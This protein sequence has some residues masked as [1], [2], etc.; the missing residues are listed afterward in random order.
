MRPLLTLS[1]AITLGCNGLAGL[2]GLTFDD[3]GGAAGAAGAGGEGGTATGMGGTSS[4]MAGMGGSG[5]SGDGGM[6]GLSDLDL[7]VRY[8][9]DEQPSGTDPTLLEDSGFEK[10]SHRWV[11]AWEM[12][13]GRKSAKVRRKAGPAPAD[14]PAETRTA[15]PAQLP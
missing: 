14:R 12:E 10:T 1:I 6:G 15:E 3:V 4:G 8:R 7:V 9:M 2:D 5:A 11:T 13:L